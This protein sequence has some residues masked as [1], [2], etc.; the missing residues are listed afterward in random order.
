MI[1]AWNEWG[2]AMMLEPSDVY[3]YELLESIPRS[4]NAVASMSCNYEKL[5]EYETE[6]DKISNRIIPNLDAYLRESIDEIKA[7]AW[8]NAR[9][10]NDLKNRLIDLDSYITNVIIPHFKIIPVNISTE[11]TTPIEK[12][13]SS[14]TN[15]GRIMSSYSLLAIGLCIVAM[16][17]FA[18]SWR[19]STVVE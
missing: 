9:T 2:E 7:T 19:L 3:G 10:P 16:L 15:N 5:H 4:K 17:L 11:V 12:I 13:D 1:N 14:S 8:S 18:Q 6:L